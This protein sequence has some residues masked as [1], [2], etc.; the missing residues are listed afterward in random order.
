MTYL[1][2]IYYR[3]KDKNIIIEGKEKGKT[4]YL[5]ALPKDPEKLIRFLGINLGDAKFPKKSSF[6]TKGKYMKIME[7]LNRLDFRTKREGSII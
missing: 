1:K 7:K 5:L 2:A 3:R 6:L 4:I